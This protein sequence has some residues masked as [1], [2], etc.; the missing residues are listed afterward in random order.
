MKGIE[1]ALAK[2]D[3]LKAVVEGMKKGLKEQLVTGLSGSARSFFISL[4]KSSLSRPVVIVTHTLYQAQKMY[5]DLVDMIDEDV[6][7]YPVNELIAS[8][9]A[10]AS[11]EMRADRVEVLNQLTRDDFSG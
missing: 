2:N 4:T 9:I 6:Y 8:E 1:Q 10:I 11:P 3:H 5:D 7:I